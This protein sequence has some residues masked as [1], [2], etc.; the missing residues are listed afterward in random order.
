MGTIRDIRMMPPMLAKEKYTEHES[1]CTASTV[2]P[3]TGAE[4]SGDFK[5]T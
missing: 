1:F 3:C 4:C 2:C 5:A